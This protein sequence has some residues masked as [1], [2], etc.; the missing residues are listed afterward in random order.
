LIWANDGQNPVGHPLSSFY[1]S[2]SSHD[3]CYQTCGSQQSSC[4]D[5]MAANL[6]AVCA[7]IPAT[8]MK[9]FEKRVPVYDYSI[10]ESPAF[11]RYD[12]VVIAKSYQTQ[13]Y[14]VADWFM[15]ILRG[16]GFIAHSK[17]Q[18]QCCQC[19]ADKG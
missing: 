1:G 15:R 3:F 11:I 10:P 8:D 17:R 13:C 16:A 9:Y 5:S 4:D 19:C 14:F 18:N 12:T 2:C 7:A 6:Q